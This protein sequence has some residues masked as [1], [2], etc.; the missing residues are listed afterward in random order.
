MDIL[1]NAKAAEWFKQLEPKDGRYVLKLMGPLGDRDLAG[2]TTSPTTVDFNGDGRRELLL[3]A[4]DGRFY[5]L[6]RE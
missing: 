1:A 6:P 5:H 4:E 2:H 3:G